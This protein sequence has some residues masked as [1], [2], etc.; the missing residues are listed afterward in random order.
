MNVIIILEDGRMAGPQSYVLKLIAKLNNLDVVLVL[1]RKD[2]DEFCSRLKS[3]G[4][5]YTEMNISRPQ[6]NLVGLI[7]YI[8]NFFPDCIRLCRLIKGNAD[9]IVY[10]A[11]GCW[12][13]KGIIA[14]KI[15]RVP[16]IWQMNDTHVPKLIMYIFRIL[17]RLPNGYI[18]VSNATKRYYDTIYKPKALK[19]I[20]P[21][22]IDI[23]EFL[24]GNYGKSSVKDKKDF[25]KPIKVGTVCSINPI[26]NLE[27]FLE[28]AEELNRTK[29]GIEFEFRIIGP[30]PQ[31]QMKY[32]NFL[33]KEISCKNLKNIKFEGAQ[34]NIPKKL[35]ELDIYLCTSKNEASPIAV[36]EALA[37]N[38]SVIS[39]DVGDVAFH[40]KKSKCGIIIPFNK[41]KKAARLLLNYYAKY[42]D[43]LKIQNK[44]LVYIDKNMSSQMCASLHEQLFNEA[45]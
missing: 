36:W 40:L 31:T 42:G 25:K 43:E 12:Q 23:K 26:K 19:Y 13:I 38:I 4:I 18:Y 21:S 11:G 1:P 24:E 17:G 27:Y 45:R 16:S 34:S 5:N 28:I 30:V 33:K 9:C 37:A 15:M 29:G 41:P 2:N 8:L 14:A 7:K 44:G 35:Q 3:A 39:T 22:P 10:S 6:R 20:I 32:F